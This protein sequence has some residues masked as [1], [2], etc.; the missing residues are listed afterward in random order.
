MVKPKANSSKKSKTTVSNPPVPS[1]FAF[2]IFGQAAANAKTTPSAK[3]SPSAFFDSSC[4]IL[5]SDE[6]EA[7]ET[8]GATASASNM[9]SFGGK[10]R[11]RLQKSARKV[12]SNVWTYFVKSEVT[13][14]NGKP[15][16]A[17][18]KICGLEALSIEHGN[19]ITL[20]RHLRKKHLVEANICDGK[21]VGEK[22]QTLHDY[23]KKNSKTKTY[24]QITEKILNVIIKVSNF[25]LTTFTSNRG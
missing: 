23:S 10:K 7:D 24:A 13:D 21:T 11:K 2:S 3:P 5:E 18:C 25:F 9:A 19:T 6:D 22:Q 14:K 1:A 16:S 4:D 8:I 17:R 15:T 20:L 12:T